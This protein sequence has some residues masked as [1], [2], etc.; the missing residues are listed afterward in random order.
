MTETEH[1]LP[2]GNSS[3][4]SRRG[5]TIRRQAGPW[6][7]QVQWLLRHMRCQGIIEA[8][9]PLGFDEQGREVLS[10]LPGEVGH[11]PL[12]QAMRTDDVLVTAAQ[13]L[14]RI[15][16]A[17]AGIAPVRLTGWQ[18][19]TRLPVEVVCHGD[20]APYNCVFEDGKLAG[21]IDF[22]HAHPGPRL[23]DLAYAL[24]R[25]APL[26]ATSNPEGFGEPGEQ[27]RRAQLFCAAYGLE[28]WSQVVTYVIARVQFM[29]ERLLEGAR[30]GDARMLANIAAGHLAIYQA[31]AAYLSEQ[32]S[33]Y[34]Q[35]FSA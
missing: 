32:R 35:A 29:A 14:R 30:L 20:F 13:L 7:R 2:G 31:D 12:L 28:D 24:Y 21:V 15:H 5:N 25:F 19:P 1:I 3:L 27:I 9:E 33:L 16:D 4:V 22:D 6:S 34:E 10:Y 18:A 23:W 11:Y 8:P 17:S 26:T